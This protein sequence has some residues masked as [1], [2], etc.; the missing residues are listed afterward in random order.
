MQRGAMPRCIPFFTTEE[1]EMANPNNPN[2]NQPAHPHGEPPG[3]AKPKPGEP[4]YV[5]PGQGEQPI[6]PNTGQPYPDNTL[7]GDLP[8]E[9]EGEARR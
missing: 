4:G 3:Q 2:P 6:D 5:K 9:G 7:P 1:I 8:D